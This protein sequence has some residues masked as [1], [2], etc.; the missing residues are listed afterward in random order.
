LVSPSC[1]EDTLVIE[2]ADGWSA[3]AVAGRLLSELGAR[4][5]KLEPPDGE[6]LRHIGPGASG[7]SSTHFRTLNTNK[8]SIALDITA[9]AGRGTLDALLAK[10]DV[11][12]TDQTTITDRV[13]GLDLDAL[14]SRHPHLVHCHFSPF[15]L[16]GPLAGR[17]GGDLVAQAMGGIIATT[18]H[19]GELPHKAGL[20]LS[21]H[22]AALMG[23]ASILAALYH[24]TDTGDGTL[25]DMSLYDGMVSLLYTFMPGYFIS[26]KAPGPQGNQHPM[27]APWD[28]YPTK[29]GWVIICMADDRQ[30]RNFLNLIGKSE[31]ADDPRYMTNDE[32][33]TDKIRPQVNQ[34]VINF[35]ADKTTDEVLEILTEGQVPAGPIY[36]LLELMEDEQF[37]SR[38][39][40]QTLLDEN[41][42]LYRTPGS[43]FKMSETPGRIYRRAPSLNEHSEIAS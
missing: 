6:R 36:N 34:L 16:T 14:T 24:R 27:A 20:P 1:I 39:M 3:G 28:N 37:Q 13:P 7:E 11:L 33:V 8:E 18:G 12:L 41:G 17:A 42:E 25:I 35:L 15:G 30:W 19:P 40:V 9:D 31:L 26:G 5:V 43:I 10:C 2:I 4:V 22:N 32:R 23:G 29:D 21:V 38:E